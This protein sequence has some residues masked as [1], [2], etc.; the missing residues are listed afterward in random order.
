MTIA[1]AAQITLKGLLAPARLAFLNW[2]TVTPPGISLPAILSNAGIDRGWAQLLAVIA[3]VVPLLVFALKSER[4]RRAPG[5]LLSGIAVGLLIAAGWFATGY[6]GADDEAIYTEHGFLVYKIA[7]LASGAVVNGA[8]VTVTSGDPLPPAHIALPAPAAPVQ[9][10]PAPP[11]GQP[12]KPPAGAP[13]PPAPP[14]SSA[15]GTLGGINQIIGA[16]PGTKGR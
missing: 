14:P 1:V 15:P 9:P 13:K 7:I 5:L 16:L 8:T 3:V 10:P 2:S 11:Q 4:L 12:P 6:L